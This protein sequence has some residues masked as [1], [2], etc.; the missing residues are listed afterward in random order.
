M[1]EETIGG[2]T[3]AALP[4]VTAV[5]EEGHDEL[6]ALYSERAHLVA[7]LAHDYKGAWQDDPENPGWILVYADLPTG[8]VSWRIHPEDKPLFEN[9]RFAPDIVWDGHSTETKYGRI[10]EAIG[11][12]Q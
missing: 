10:R 8:Q 11:A 7:L 6:D 2:G 3:G 4:T 1:S 12:G 9:L 5:P